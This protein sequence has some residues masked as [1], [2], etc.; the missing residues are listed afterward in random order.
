MERRPSTW[1]LAVLGVL[2]G[3]ALLVVACGVSKDEF[4]TTKDQLAAEQQKTAALQ[5]ELSKNTVQVGT[6]QQQIAA[7]DKQIADLNKTAGA[8]QDTTVLIGAKIVPTPTPRPSPT[9]VPANFTP[10]PA[11]TPPP[12]VYDPVGPFAFYATTLT[13]GGTSKYGVEATLQCVI[14]S[15]FKRGQK[16]AWQ[17][18]IMDV[19]TG[20][21]VTD[22]DAP[23]IVVNIPGQDPA[24]PR[25]QQRGSGQVP[26]APWMWT[27]AWVIPPD[28][29]LGSVDYN[30]KVTTKDGRTGTFKPPHTIDGGG[31]EPIINNMGLTVIP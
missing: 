22:K 16:L 19:S 14:E 6:L 17:M 28:Y 10:A 15:V 26:D 3:A 7:K 23:T 13:T 18:E 27:A 20:K 29:P 4:N 8:L 25:F 30:I 11:A 12:S 5:Q 21:R 1:K 9:P 31:A 24:T 2:A